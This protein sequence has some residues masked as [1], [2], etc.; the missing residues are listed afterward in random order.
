MIQNRQ[1]QIK[2]DTQTIEKEVANQLQQIQQNELKVSQSLQSIQ[3]EFEMV[4]FNIKNQ[5]AEVG[6]QVESQKKK[7]LEFSQSLDKFG[8]KV[9]KILDDIELNDLSPIKNQDWAT[10]FP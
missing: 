10:G 3:N 2:K 5:I 9:Q 1:N 8:V 4:G 7:H 6:G